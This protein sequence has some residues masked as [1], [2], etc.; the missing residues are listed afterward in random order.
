MTNINNFFQIDSQ[1]INYLQTEW[2]ELLANYEIQEEIAEKYFQQLIEKYSEKKRFYHNLS[3]IYALL[4]S[5]AKLKDYFQDYNSVQ[6]AIWFHD[7]IY[8]TKK[9]NNEEKSAELAVKVLVELNIPTNTINLVEKM[10]IATKTHSINDL[11]RDGQIFLD[12]DLS[13]LGASPEVYQQYYQAI[14]KEYS[15]VPWFLYRRS[16]KSVLSSFLAR[17]HIF[18]TDELAKLEQIAR[19]NI[20]KE[21]VFLS[22]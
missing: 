17:E 12:L 10:I 13:I 19:Q 2:K 1:G 18:F 5:A 22:K 20:S 9:S 3:H 11:I 7:A 6:L 14:R 16:R 21:I 8:N 15:W 4:K